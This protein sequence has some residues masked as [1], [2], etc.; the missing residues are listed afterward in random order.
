MN[1]ALILI[2]AGSLAALIWFSHRLA[3]VRIYHADEC[4]NVYM[5]NVMATGQTNELFT[6]AQAC[7]SGA[8]F[9][10]WHAAQT[11]RL[12]FLWLRAL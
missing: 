12:I 8:P 9:P 10:G 5:A 6:R 2:L 7:S 1:R 4:Q 11:S 3:G